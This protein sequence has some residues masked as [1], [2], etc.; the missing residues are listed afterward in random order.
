MSIWKN[1]K[2]LEK[3]TNNKR[4]KVGS[5]SGTY[6]VTGRSMGIIASFNGSD[7]GETENG[8]EEFPE[9][10]NQHGSKS[11]ISGPEK[12]TEKEK[13]DLKRTVKSNQILATY[14]QIK[15]RQTKKILWCWNELLGFLACLSRMMPNGIA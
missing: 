14:K 7:V 3:P 6:L 15:L 11:I 9:E 8:P 12:M 1:P 13:K 10:L 5:G 4:N 2:P